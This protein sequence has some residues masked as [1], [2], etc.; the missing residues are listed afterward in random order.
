MAGDLKY[1]A[2]FTTSIDKGIYV[3]LYNYSID[4]QI[5]LSRLADEA[6]EDFLKKYGVEFS[7]EA[8]YKRAKIMS[9]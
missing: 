8:P 6:F 2:R 4:S 5:P 1:R 9:L 3:A 7:R